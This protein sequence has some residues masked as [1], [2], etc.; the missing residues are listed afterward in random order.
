VRDGGRHRDRFRQDPHYLTTDLQPDEILTAVRI[1][2]LG[3]SWGYRYE[4]FHRTAQS[5][6]TVGVAALT[7]RDNGSVAEARI[8][9][10]NMGTVPVRARAAE[11]AVAGVQASRGALRPRPT[12]PTRAPSRPLT[13]TGPPTTGGI[14]PAC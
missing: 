3:P 2:K 9:L 1:P 11:D 12:G 13:C 4:K 10:T 5:W 8:G 14:W 6:A 7:R